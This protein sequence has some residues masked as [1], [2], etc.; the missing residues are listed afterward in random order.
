MAGRYI[1]QKRNGMRDPT[2]T[3]VEDIGVFQVGHY[4]LDHHD[5]SVITHI[6]ELRDDLR[7]IHFVKTNT[8]VAGVPVHDLRPYD[9]E[10]FYQSAVVARTGQPVSEVMTLDEVRASYGAMLDSE[11]SS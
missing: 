4:I 11:D 1:R 8:N 9:V 2:M 3:H 7:F 10:N 5:K 6:D